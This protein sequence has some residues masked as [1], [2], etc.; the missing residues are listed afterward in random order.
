MQFAR[1]VK[2]E[3]VDSVSWPICLSEAHIYDQLNS[4]KQSQYIHNTFLLNLLIQWELEI[5]LKIENLSFVH[6]HKTFALLLDKAPC[7]LLVWEI[8]ETY[9]AIGDA[10]FKCAFWTF[11]QQ[12]VFKMWARCRISIVLLKMSLYCVFRDMVTMR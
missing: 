2:V 11:K 5:D 10:N 9:P 7:F 1:L 12:L 3:S 8:C 6:V 4:N